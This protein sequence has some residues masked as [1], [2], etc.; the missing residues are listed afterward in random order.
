MSEDTISKYTIKRL[1]KDIADI[2]KNPLQDQGIYYRHDDTN[3]LIGYALIIGPEDTPYQYGFYH[4]RIEYPATYP[5]SPP[6]VTF[7]TNRDQIRFNPNLYRNGKCCL[8]ILNTWSGDQ[9]SACQTLRTILLTLVTVFNKTPFLNEPSI[10]SAHVDYDSYHK[11]IEYSNI[12]IAFMGTIN[13][14]INT[15]D[16][17]LFDKDIQQLYSKNIRLVQAYVKKEN[18]N[19]LESKVYINKLYSV[20]C[21]CDYK[22]IYDELIK[23]N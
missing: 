5:D 13:K 7:L 22:K 11:K 16:Y 12:K 3:M 20:R 14:D 23:L 8:S 17:S 2:A 4:F 6:K 18:W 19:N 9:W 21:L 15:I 10:T 1:V